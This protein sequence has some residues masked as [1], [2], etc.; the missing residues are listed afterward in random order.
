MT[1]AQISEFSLILGALGLTL[2]HINKDTMSLI[3][4]VGLITISISTYMI[5]YSY[6]LYDQLKRWLVL[7]DR[8][9]TKPETI[10]EMNT[11]SEAE[12]I[13]FGLGRLGALIAQKLCQKGD[14]VIGV[15]F[16]P[17]LIRYH[18]YTGYEIRYGNAEDSEFLNSLPLKKVRWIVSSVR[19]RNINHTLLHGLLQQGYSGQTAF[20][21]HS[22]RDARSLKQAGADFVVIPYAEVAQEVVD[23][24][25]E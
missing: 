2:G 9:T 16:N 7:F 11:M 17:D 12:F 8:K 15:D 24:L 19:D 25:L 5:L 22:E 1:V 20:S 18:A 23:R 4:L 14:R 10:Q 21:S 13:I 3:T 6:P